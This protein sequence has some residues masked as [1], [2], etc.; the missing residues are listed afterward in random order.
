MTYRPR[1]N[2]KPDKNHSIPM[3]YLKY[4]CGGFEDTKDGNTICY[5]A[6]YKGYS[7]L[8]FDLSKFGGV[9]TDWLIQCADNNRFF[10][11]ES[12]TPEA[13]RLKDNDKTNGEKWLSER[14][15]NFRF[16]VEDLDMEKILQELI[17]GVT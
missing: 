2:T 8:L 14:V 5:T 17:G 16:C 13:Y 9:L 7:V 15:S 3:E 12:K 11:L 6:N 10:W 1:Y 4:C